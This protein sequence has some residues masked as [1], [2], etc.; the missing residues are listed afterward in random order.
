MAKRLFL[1]TLFAAFTAL[2]AG[3]GS[4]SEKVWAS[5]YL[6]QNEPPADGAPQARGEIHRQLKEVFGY[7]HYLMVKTQEFDLRREWGQWFVPRR[8]FFIRLEPVRP[9]PASA[10]SINYEIYKDG[11]IVATGTYEPHEETPLFIKGPD[12]HLGRLIFVL[13]VR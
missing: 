9:D 12:F 1:L 11:F 2:A 4:A 5:L 10:R 6:A 3:T 13:Q 7:R 8:D